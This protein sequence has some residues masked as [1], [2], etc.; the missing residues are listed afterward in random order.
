MCD[1]ELSMTAKYSWSGSNT[2]P[3]SAGPCSSIGGRKGEWHKCDTTG[4]VLRV[5]DPIKSPSQIIASV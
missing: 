2:L 4:C 5:K 3:D 1:V